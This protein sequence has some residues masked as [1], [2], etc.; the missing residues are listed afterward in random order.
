MIHWR[1]ITEDGEHASHA[2]AEDEFLMGKYAEWSSGEYPE[3]IL[4]I[5]TFRSHCAIAGRFQNLDAE[6]DL[7]EC[8]KRGI[9]VN[10]RI[11]GGGAV[12][13]G[14]D[15]LMISLAS[16]T[17][18]PIV[19]AHPGRMIPKLSRGVIL[20]LAKLGIKASF[21]PKNDIVVNGRKIGGTAICVA[22]SGSLLYQANV[23]LDFDADLMLDVIATPFEKRSDMAVESFR[24]RLT[25]V[26]RELNRPVGVQHAREAIC[27]GFEQAFKMSAVHSPVTPTEKEQI[28][29]LEMEKYRSDSWLHQRQPAKDMLGSYASRTPAGVI[30]VYVALLGDTLKNVLITGD[31]FSGNR[32]VND[33]EAALKWGRIEPD[34]V[35]RTIRVVMSNSGGAIQGVGADQLAEM[36]SLAIDDALKTKPR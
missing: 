6:I 12:V 9:D 25:T 32:V 31:F 1:Y 29:H 16:S 8:R 20:G 11:T 23:M 35:V 36:V 22:E 26:A 7:A 19:P 24:D 33:I 13:F 14:G 10:R 2:L 3:P 4:R 17:E 28:E 5:Y 27:R 18:H 34:S 15:V 21:R 30:Q